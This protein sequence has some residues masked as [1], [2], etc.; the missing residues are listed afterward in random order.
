MAIYEIS[1]NKIKE[2]I[3]ETVNGE[4]HW[5]TSV[6]PEQI[7]SFYYEYLSPNIGDMSYSN[8]RNEVY[9]AANQFNVNSMTELY[10][11]FNDIEASAGGYTGYESI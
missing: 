5:F 11:I 7:D 2:L 4:K 10:N 3:K 9:H 8:R 6:S 1:T